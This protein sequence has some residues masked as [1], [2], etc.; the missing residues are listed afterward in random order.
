M[1]VPKHDPP[2]SNRRPRVGPVLLPASGR[3][4]PTPHWPLVGRIDPVVMIRWEQLWSTPQAVAWERMGTATALM[5]ARYCLMVVAAES[6]DSTAAL[7]AQVVA[8]ED[9]LGLSPKAMRM[10]LWQI[11][12]DE[13]AER[14]GGRSEGVRERLR[15]VETG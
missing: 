9:R 3:S 11:A 15:A 12:P 2:S 5:V 6:P 10:L 13:V 7:L 1:Q 14:R 4:G 8:L